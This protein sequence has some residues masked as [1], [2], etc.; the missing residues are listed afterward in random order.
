MTRAEIAIAIAGVALAA[1]I[2]GWLAHWLFMR[3]SA[4]PGERKDRADEL[5]A[6]LLAVEA[7]RDRSVAV[8]KDAEESA[9][10]RLRE[11]EAELAAAMDALGAARAEIEELRSAGG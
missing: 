5:A 11:R 7:E 3:L 1:F 4:G 8:A 9:T 10:A 6:E 2:A